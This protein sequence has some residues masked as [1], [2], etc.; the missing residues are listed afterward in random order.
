[1]N[2][3]IFRPVRV[4]THSTDKCEKIVFETDGAKV[5]LVT[6]D[7]GQGYKGK[8][9][10]TDAFYI[11]HSKSEAESTITKNPEI[12]QYSGFYSSAWGKRCEYSAFAIDPTKTHASAVVKFFISLTDMEFNQRA[13]IGAL[14]CTTAEKL[15]SSNFRE[16]NEG[17]FFCTY[18]E[19]YLV[20]F[21]AY[22]AAQNA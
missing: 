22:E 5:F 10:F 9:N 11:Q 8:F 16:T 6:S 3:V 15:M 18:Q 17:F 13:A 21:K 12:W 2:I 14:L 1:M 4:A 19:R 7:E 20:A